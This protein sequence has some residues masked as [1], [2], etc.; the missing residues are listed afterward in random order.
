MFESLA[1]VTYAE[2]KFGRSSSYEDRSFFN[3]EAG[4]KCSQSQTRADSARPFEVE[5]E[6][7]DDDE[8]PF[9]SSCM[10][11]LWLWYD[12]IIAPVDNLH[13]G[14]KIIVFPERELHR[15]PFQATEDEN[16][17]YLSETSV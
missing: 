11:A 8:V 3:F 17:N 5:E 10:T 14:S 2:Y 16:G 7:D 13:E 12:I 15:V 6:D 4:Q 9:D 1:N